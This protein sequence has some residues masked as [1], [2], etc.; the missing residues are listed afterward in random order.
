[1]TKLYVNDEITR[2]DGRN[3]GF[4]YYFCLT[5]EGSELGS[6]SIPLTNGSGSGSRRPKKHV[7]PDPQ[8]WFLGRHFGSD[9]ESAIRIRIS[10]QEYESGI[11]IRNPN[12]ESESGIRIRNPNPESESWIWI[13]IHWSDWIQIRNTV[14]LGGIIVL[15]KKLETVPLKNLKFLI[16]TIF[17][18]FFLLTTQGLAAFFKCLHDTMTHNYV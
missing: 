14:F 9:P 7:D 15:A 2:F 4:S 16:K 8:H 12:P 3:Q 13:Q 6:G 1:M 17:L 11:L 18:S 5:I 10:N